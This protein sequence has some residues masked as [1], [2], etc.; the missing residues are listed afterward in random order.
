MGHIAEAGRQKGSLK[1]AL[2]RKRKIKKKRAKY[3]ETI[4]NI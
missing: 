1:F 2:E 3:V 4:L